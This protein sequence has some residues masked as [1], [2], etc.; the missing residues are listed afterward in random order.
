MQ[1]QGDFKE[2]ELS[3]T[4]W[5]FQELGFKKKNVDTSAQIDEK[6]AQSDEKSGQ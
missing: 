3:R 5:A 2:D 1:V 6:S 4:L